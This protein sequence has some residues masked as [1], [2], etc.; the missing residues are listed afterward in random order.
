MANNASTSTQNTTYTE[1]QSTQRPPFFNGLNYS[2][3][4]TRMSFFMQSSSYDAW[5][6]TQREIVNPTTDY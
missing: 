6:A 1:G 3:W 2:Y 5:N 4:A